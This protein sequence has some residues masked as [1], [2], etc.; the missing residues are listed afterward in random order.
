[1][2]APRDDRAL[3]TGKGRAQ[4]AA[5][6]D[7]IAARYDRLNH[8]L[9]MGL[10]RRW[11]SQAIDALKLSGRETLLDLCTG[12]ADLALCSVQRKRGHA[13]RAI[14]LDFAHEMLRHGR[15]K[16]RQSK[17]SRVALVRGDAT[18]LPVASSTVDA[19]TIGFG[20]RN[21]EEPG[22]ALEEIHRVLRPGGRVAIL[23]FAVP[24]VPVL[25]GIYM[26]YFR[27]VVPRL[28][29]AISGHATAYSYLPASVV[30]FL[31]PDELTALLGAAGFNCA[32]AR[33]LTFGT[34]YLHVA[35]KQAPI[36]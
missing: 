28:G 7:A 32:D 2:T 33:P 22:R 1:M 30:A 10:D 6:F 8:L 25:R 36:V 14:G 24:G 17:E 16:V 31:A 34:V 27:R 29:R 13:G 19:V 4:I 12:T 11:R 35:T 5:M 3:A 26:W 23:E 18:S 20:I 21:V 9:S 15:R